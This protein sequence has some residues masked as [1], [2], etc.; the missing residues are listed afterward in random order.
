MSSFYKSLLPKTVY[1]QQGK[2]KPQ[3]YIIW[4]VNWDKLE[5]DSI[6]RKMKP[7]LENQNST[8]FQK[9]SKT[10]RGNVVHSLR[11]SLYNSKHL[12]SNNYNFIHYNSNL[13]LSRIFYGSGPLLNLGLTKRL[14]PVDDVK[15]INKGLDET[16]FLSIKQV[17]LS[18]TGD[19]FTE[20]Y[21]L[22]PI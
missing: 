19:S 9:F 11:Y 6:P 4:L 18:Q 13:F 21:Y 22:L 10:K 7:R 20:I 3:K 14:L 5:H 15:M 8:I 2:I 16:T 12:N 1:K 17:P